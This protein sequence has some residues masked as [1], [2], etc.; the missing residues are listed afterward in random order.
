MHLSSRVVS[1]CVGMLA[2]LC[3]QQTLWAC[4]DIA[5]VDRNARFLVLDGN[6]L[7]EK[8]VGNLWWLG[9]RVVDGVI[10]GSTAERAGVNVD[11][12]VDPATD[13]RTVG[14]EGA[15]LVVRNLGG[16]SVSARRLSVQMTGNAWWVDDSTNSRL[17]VETGSSERRA[18]TVL[19]PDLSVQI[20]RPAGDLGLPVACRDAAR[21]IIA[22]LRSG[23][24]ITDDGASSV[25]EF[26]FPKTSGDFR[27]GGLTP[28]GCIGL[29]TEFVE[30]K[31]GDI[32]IA[33]TSL[34]TI[35]LATDVLGPSFTARR[36]AELVL[37]S[38]GARL[39]LNELH[40]TGQAETGYRV[41]PTGRVSVI[42]TQTGQ[43]LKSA[44]LKRA[45][46]A[47]R[48]FCRGKDEKIVL[49]SPQH[50]QLLD[51]ATLSVIASRTIPFD[52]YFVF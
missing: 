19:N 2:G 9:I 20:E 50:L 3:C 39:L 17:I 32:N 22:G 6:T 1:V 30:H 42:D 4:E 5:V 40:A 10:K 51:L 35:D 7:E 43:V 31:Q 37:F 34:R 13:T 23:I 29:M 26:K 48:L 21:T 28:V 11:T 44:A 33:T 18:I 27:N 52:R 24:V 8:D 46:T 36:M 12:L 25:K 47:S 49:V 45:G 14:P 16:S 41:A 15:F 38:R